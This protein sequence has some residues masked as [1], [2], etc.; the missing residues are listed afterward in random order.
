MLRFA[1]ASRRSG[2][3]SS[4]RSGTSGWTAFNR[5]VTLKRLAARVEAAIVQMPRVS[6]FTTD[7]LLMEMFKQGR[8]VLGE[9]SPPIVQTLPSVVA[10]LSR[11]CPPKSPTL[12]HLCFRK[13]SRFKRW[14]FQSARLFTKGWVSQARVIFASRARACDRCFVVCP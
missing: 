1:M 6:T 13:R 5:Q 3:R 7:Y 2:R 8:P 9:H 11:P 4:G 14:V 12:G 10:R